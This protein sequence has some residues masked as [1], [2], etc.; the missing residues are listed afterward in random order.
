[1]HARSLRRCGRHVPPY[2]FRMDGARVSLR[3]FAGQDFRDASP[4]LSKARAGLKAACEG[5]T[6]GQL[7]IELGDTASKVAAFHGIG[8]QA[9]GAIVSRAR[10][11]L[12]IQAAKQ[13]RAGGVIEIVR[14]QFSRT[15]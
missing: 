13:V 1:C 15:A 9:E 8:G 11:L 3:E 4:R 14:V 2:D 12:S 5:R 10:L 6:T 7:D